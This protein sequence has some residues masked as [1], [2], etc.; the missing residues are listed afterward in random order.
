MR[1]KNMTGGYKKIDRLQQAP[2]G[3]GIAEGCI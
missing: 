2:G 3:E 1:K